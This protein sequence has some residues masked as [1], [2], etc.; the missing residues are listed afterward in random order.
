MKGRLTKKVHFFA[1]LSNSLV[2]SERS[3]YFTDAYGRHKM[4][5][6][7]T[8]AIHIQSVAFHRSFIGRRSPLYVWRLKSQLR[9]L[10]QILP[11]AESGAAAEISITFKHWFPPPPARTQPDPPQLCCGNIFNNFAGP[12]FWNIFFGPTF[13]TSLLGQLFLT[14]L[15]GQLF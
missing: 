6:R 1:N 4:S 14:T 15:L 2:V 7:Q 5:S 8:S 9:N 3:W 13:L 12:T 11:P 10:H